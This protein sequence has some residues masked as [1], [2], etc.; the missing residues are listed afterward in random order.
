MG[1]GLDSAIGA[2][3]GLA[4]G[5]FGGLGRN[6]A[7]KKMQKA[8]EQQKREN[9]DLYD[10]RFNEDFTQRA[11]AQR[12]LQ[13][14]EDSIKKRNQAAAGTAAVMGGSDESIAAEK[15]ANAQ[16]LA[17]V[18]GQINAAGEQYKQAVEDRYLQRKQMLDEQLMKLR[19]QKKSAWDIGADAIAG[20]AEGGVS[21]TGLFDK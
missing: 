5:I 12:L 9:Q 21:F 3:L 20:A 16:S 14:T 17:D 10:R 8:I 2:G 6:K 11:D 19:G 4:S 15:A 1:L 7:L 18:T 13:M